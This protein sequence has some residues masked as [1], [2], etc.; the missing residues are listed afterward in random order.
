LNHADY[1]CFEW[2]ESYLEDGGQLQAQLVT[3]GNVEL[4]L[5]QKGTQF[6][7]RRPTL[8]EA[9]RAAMEATEA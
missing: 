2:L 6:H 5:S 4:T 8:R 7:V 1:S 3:T 9:V